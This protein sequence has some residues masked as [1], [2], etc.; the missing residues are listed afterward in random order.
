VKKKRAFTLFE[1]I[2]A[3]ALTALCA[4]L[5]FSIPFRIAKK[6][7]GAIFVSE[8]ERLADKESYKLKIDLLCKGHFWNEMMKSNDFPRVLEQKK[9]EVSF[10]NRQKRTYVMK[11]EI[12]TIKSKPE[13]K[14]FE[15][16]ISLKCD[17]EKKESRSFIYFFTIPV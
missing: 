11:N 10:N 1:V 13:G 5:L 8:L 12:L 16:K 14:L 6:E 4:P 3:I 2:I 15:V 17:S 7:I 9:L